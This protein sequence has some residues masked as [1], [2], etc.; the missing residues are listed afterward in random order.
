MP[1]QTSRIDYVL[2]VIARFLLQGNAPSRSVCFGLQ[3]AGSSRRRRLP[4]R[5]CIHQRSAP[6]PFDA[7]DLCSSASCTLCKQCPLRVVGCP[8]KPSHHATNASSN[9][10]N[11]YK[12]IPARFQLGQRAVKSGEVRQ[13][14]WDDELGPGHV[15]GMA[16][17][18]QE[19]S[20]SDRS[21]HPFS[22][23]SNGRLATVSHCHFSLTRHHSRLNLHS[24]VVG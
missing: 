12:Y 10:F 8:E 4:L 20:Y 18:R 3:V 23:S 14:C 9:R 19:R 6:S 24:F 22:P 21:P 15:P 11:F 2:G 13:G 5:H 17:G 7:P 16:C 1:I